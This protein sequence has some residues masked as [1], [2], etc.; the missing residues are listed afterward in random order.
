MVETDKNK[1]KPELKTSRESKPLSHLEECA[2]PIQGT[3]GCGTNM[4]H[5]GSIKLNHV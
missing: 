1:D 5:L 4:F 2:I 3:E